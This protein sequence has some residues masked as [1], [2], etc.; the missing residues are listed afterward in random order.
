MSESF[1]YFEEMA[2]EAGHQ[3]VAGVD[4]AGRG[5]LAGPVVAAACLLPR[6]LILEGIDDSKK[7]S[8]KQREELYHLLVNHPEVDFGVAI[9]DHKRIDAINILRASLEAMAFAVKEMA[10]QP[11]FLLIDGNQLPP[12]RTPSKT[13]IKGDSRSQSIAAASIIA[14]YTRDQLMIEYHEK[15]PEYGFDKHKGYATQS[16][17]RAIHEHGPCPVHRQSFEPIKSLVAK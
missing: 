17:V 1:T 7:L 4:E 11:D 6:G 5:P 2:F 13:V 3:L 10:V 15:W 9:R 12:I 16:H 14:K 8:P